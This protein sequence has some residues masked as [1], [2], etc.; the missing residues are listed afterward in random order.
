M[1]GNETFPGRNACFLHGDVMEKP[2]NEERDGGEVLR[3]ATRQVLVSHGV[4][5]SWREYVK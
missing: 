1:P 3:T 5:F 2:G 4:G